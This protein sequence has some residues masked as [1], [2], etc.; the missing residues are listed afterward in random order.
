[1]YDVAS[2]S[3]VVSFAVSLKRFLLESVMCFEP[4]G[5]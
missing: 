5:I 1:M 3:A 2:R 4:A